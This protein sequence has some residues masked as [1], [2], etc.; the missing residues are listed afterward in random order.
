VVIPVGGRLVRA[1]VVGDAG[2][3]WLEWCHPDRA[4]R[5]VET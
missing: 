2:C 3:G 5:P 1:L 4:V